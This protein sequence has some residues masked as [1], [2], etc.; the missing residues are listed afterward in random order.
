VLFILAE[1][2]GGYL[3]HS[4]A[5]MTDAFHMISDLGSFIIS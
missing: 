2:A 3:A 5:I 1:L 4:L